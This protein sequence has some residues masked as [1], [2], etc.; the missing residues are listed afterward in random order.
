MRCGC[1]LLLRP[2]ALCSWSAVAYLI[3]NTFLWC[4]VV[5]VVVAV[6]RVGVFSGVFSCGEVLVASAMF[7][8]KQAS[9]GE[10]FRPGF[11]IGV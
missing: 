5:V 8:A 2:C 9:S 3:L 7:V 11:C 10:G 1:L 6:G 4:F